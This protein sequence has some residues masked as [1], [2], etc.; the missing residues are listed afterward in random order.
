MSLMTSCRRLICTH[1]LV[2]ALISIQQKGCKCYNP[3]IPT[4]LDQNEVILK[5]WKDTF[6]M[7]KSLATNATR[8]LDTLEVVLVGDS[9]TE[10]WHGSDLSHHYDD[11]NGHA[12]VFNTL[13]KKENG[14]KV[15]GKFCDADGSFLA[16]K[17]LMPTKS[18]ILA[19]VIR[20]YVGRGS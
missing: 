12:E 8:D 10:H 14:G 5:R 20:G 15:N 3:T 11:F 4:M 13:F 16:K 7:T 9:I 18:C 6:Q 1:V 17:S 19:S 2:D